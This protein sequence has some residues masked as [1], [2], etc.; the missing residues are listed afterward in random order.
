MGGSSGGTTVYNPTPPPAPSVGSSI[1]DY[2]NALPQLYAAQEQ[3]APQEAAQQ[4]Q[5]AQQYAAPLAQAYQS[6]QDVLYP[7]TS[8]LQEQLAQ[9]AQQGIQAGVPQSQQDQYRSDLAGQLGSNVNSGIGAD[10]VSR[11][12][13]NQ[14]QQYQQYYQNLGLSLAGRQPL[15][16]PTSPQTTSQ[17]GQY[18][19]GEVLGYNSNIYGS[20]VGGSRPITTQSGTPNWISGLQAGGSALQGIGSLRSFCWVASKI[21]GGWYKTETIWARVYILTNCPKWFINLY[22]KYGENLSKNSIAL[23]ILKPLFEY[24]SIKGKELKYG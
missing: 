7:G 19:P 4:V 24:F 3:Y 23:S 20:Q 6:A 18:N 9:Q 11:N 10:Y 1:T 14:Q 5:L 12:L 8:Q 13:M 2:I 15:V 22:K 17:L 16:N 21:F